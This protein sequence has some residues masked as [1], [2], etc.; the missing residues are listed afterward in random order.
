MGELAPQLPAIA[1][2]HGRVVAACL[3]LSSQHACQTQPGA[4]HQPGAARQPAAA[5]QPAAAH[6]RVCCCHGEQDFRRQMTSQLIFLWGSVTGEPVSQSSIFV[7]GKARVHYHGCWPYL[8]PKA[9]DVL[10]C[11]VLCATLSLLHFSCAKFKGER[12]SDYRS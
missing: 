6:C 11:I 9:A 4:A 8:Y 1:E 12:S 7:A 10:Y 5:L 2:G 3:S